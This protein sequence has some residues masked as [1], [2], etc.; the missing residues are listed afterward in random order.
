MKYGVYI[1]QAGV[2]DAG[3]AD[4]RTDLVDWAIVEYIR[5]WQLSPKAT[6][7][8][9]LVWINYK[10]LI[11]E[12]P[13]LGLNNKQ[14]VSKRVVKLSGLGLIHTDHDGHGRVFCRLSERCLSIITFRE[15]GQ[16]E[17]TGVNSGERGVNHSG[18]GPVNHGGHSTVNYISTDNQEHRP[19]DGA[20]AK[21]LKRRSRI[22]DDWE[23]EEDDPNHLYAK[24]NGMT[25]AE[26]IVE[27]EK[28]RNHHIAKG[29]VMID[30]SAAWRT[31]VTNWLT[32]RRGPYGKTQK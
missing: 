19:P 28:F 5:D 30:W 27:E 3:F 15:S 13:L 6:K 11:G 8:G 21:I 32:Y 2:A 10:H 23:I 22:P 17:L 26:L 20:K 4:G 7:L 24:S 1:N 18:R 31:W 9:D 12:M 25:W 29:T 16:P 14:A